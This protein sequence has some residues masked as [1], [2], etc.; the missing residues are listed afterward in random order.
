M[1]FVQPLICGKLIKRYKRFLAD[2]ELEDGSVVT[3]HSANTGSM[4][5]CSSPGST[6]WLSDSKSITRKYPLSWELVEADSGALTG[7]NT[8]WPNKLV[9]EAIEE[10]LGYASIRAEVKYG[11]ENSRIDLLLE[12]ADKGLC[13]VEVKSVTLVQDGKALFPDAVTARGTKHL[14]ELMAMVE[15]GH[16]AVIFYCIQRGD[17]SSFA[18]A[19]A[20]DP[21]YG[22][23]LRKA[24][25]CG[26]EAL[27]YEADV[28]IGEIFISKKIPL[29]P[30][31]LK[32]NALFLLPVRIPLATLALGKRCGGNVI[33][34]S[35][36]DDSNC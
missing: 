15:Q 20:I 22:E 5:G 2:V 26:V 27:A 14:R 12:D 34:L 6:V 10:L 21:L 30:L 25:S 29:E 35:I 32:P 9:K 8:G 31:F 23:T 28:S 18:P 7:I 16:R 1:K 3:A 24:I 36:Y 17:T 19:D 4:T 11:Q 33:F 13:Y